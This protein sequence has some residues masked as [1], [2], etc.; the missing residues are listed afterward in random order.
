MKTMES[1]NLGAGHEKTP[2]NHASLLNNRQSR[3]HKIRLHR[4][5]ILF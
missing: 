3:T 1:P 5:N 2:D 4:S